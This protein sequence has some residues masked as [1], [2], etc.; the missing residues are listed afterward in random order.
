MVSP[1]LLEDPFTRRSPTRAC[2]WSYILF[3]SVAALAQ[4]EA[5]VK[6]ARTYAI[7]EGLGRRRCSRSP[8]KSRSKRSAHRRAL[9]APLN[10][11]LPLMSEDED[12]QFP[13]K[14]WNRLQVS[15]RTSSNDCLKNST[16]TSRCSD[17]GGLQIVA[18]PADVTEIIGCL[19]GGSGS[20][21]LQT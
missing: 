3:V 17:A 18:S 16:F 8:G 12:R 13:A 5:T 19:G 14:P 2:E 11:R 9:L 1:N 21:I 20:T 6:M 15:R 4:C 10:R 7:G